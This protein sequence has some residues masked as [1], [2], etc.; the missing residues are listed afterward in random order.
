MATEIKDG[1]GFIAASMA[2]V[3]LFSI[4]AAGRPNTQVSFTP[5]DHIQVNISA[6]EEI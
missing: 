6:K 2:T 4:K 1:A 5:S 3:E